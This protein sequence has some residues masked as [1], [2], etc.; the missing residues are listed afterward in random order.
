MPAAATALTASFA[1]TVRLRPSGVVQRIVSIPPRRSIE[2]SPEKQSAQ[3]S[4]A[5]SVS[6][7]SA[8]PVKP[9]SSR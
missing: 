1:R 7:T 9:N 6:C 5:S 4:P 8:W 3:A 2:N